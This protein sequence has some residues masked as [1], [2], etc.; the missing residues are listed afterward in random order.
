MESSV[1]AKRDN[2]RYIKRHAPRPNLKSRFG[3]KFQIISRTEPVTFFTRH[4]NRSG[5]SY[6]DSCSGSGRI[7]D[8]TA[9][10][11]TDRNQECRTRDS[12]SVPGFGACLIQTL[13]FITFPSL[14]RKTLSSPKIRD[15]SEDSSLH[16]AWS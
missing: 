16:S 8:T 7:A 14:K 13:F 6:P 5:E 2:C 9:E 15:F 1:G 12:L 4:P 10:H 11:T 3:S